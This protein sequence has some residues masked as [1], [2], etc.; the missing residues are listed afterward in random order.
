MYGG[1]GAELLWYPVWSDLAVGFEAAALKKRTYSG[2]GFVDTVRKLDFMT[3]SYVKF[4]PYQYFANAYYDWRD[5]QLD[6]KVTIGKFLA[7]DF[8]VRAEVGHYFP[9]GLRVYGWAARTS[10]RDIINGE[11]IHDKGVGI[12]FPLDILKTHCSRK[13]WNYSMSAWQRD[14]AARTKTGRDLYTMI[15]ELRRD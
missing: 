13:R 9:N 1:V 10:A 8:G 12:S 7:R 5:V 11:R 6:F 15:S 2:I 4:F 14:T 3:P